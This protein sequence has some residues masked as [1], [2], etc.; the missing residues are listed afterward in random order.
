LANVIPFVSFK[1]LTEPELQIDICAVSRAG[2][3][4]KRVQ[5]LTDLLR[6]SAWEGIS[7]VLQRLELDLPSN[8]E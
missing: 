5:P 7:G 6:A 8:V 4:D 3:D 1:L 2:S